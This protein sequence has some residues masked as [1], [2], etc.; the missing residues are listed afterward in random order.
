M[1][2]KATPERK[3]Q[4]SDRRQQILAIAARLFGTQG[5]SLTTVR[6]IADEAG[7]LSG[8]LYH[9]FESKEAIGREILLTFLDKLLA[10]YRAAVAEP[11]DPMQQLERLVRVS[12]QAINDDPDAV[13]LFQNESLFL[14]SE[15]GFEFLEE[16]ANEV[17]AI[18][19]EHLRQGQEVGT[20]R[21]SL[22]LPVLRRFMRDA[23][24]S[25]VRW[26]HPG[27]RHTTDSLATEF[28]DLISHG[29]LATK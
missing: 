24:W 17:E 1:A 18:W 10:Q 23:I 21:D 5:Y 25:T 19:T 12:F 3:K 26:Y 7:I 6:D 14:R 27:G 28:L 8:S 29:I 16:R 15:L 11:G 22:D 4:G 13:G 2:Q 20:F 9:H